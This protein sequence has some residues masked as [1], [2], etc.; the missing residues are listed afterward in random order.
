MWFLAHHIITQAAMIVK[1]NPPI[2]LYAEVRSAFIRQGTTLN[3][4]CSENGI[5]RQTA[6]KSLKRERSG[7]NAL[8]LRNRLTAA[9]GVV[10]VDTDE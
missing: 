10:L 6:A 7:R 3:K 8:K 9:A 2:S 1:P 4:W 5:L